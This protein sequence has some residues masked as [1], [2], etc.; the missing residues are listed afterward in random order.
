MQSLLRTKARERLEKLRS[1]A[2]PTLEDAERFAKIAQARSNF[3]VFCE[4]IRIAPKETGPRVPLYRNAIQNLFE[5]NR[6]GR[7]IALKPRQ[8]GFTTLELAR[9]LWTF[10]TRDGA[11]VVVVCQSVSDNSPA[12][13]LSGV[14]K[15]MIEGLR[16]SGWSIQFDTDAWNEWVLPN[17]NSLR[18]ISAGASDASADKKG[19]AGTITRLH[20][21]EVAF[22]EHADKTLNALLECVP[23]PETGSEI[24]LES[25]ANG[26]AGYFYQA[27][28]TS[29]AHKSVYK[30]HFYG[31]FDHPEYRVPLEPGEVV[32]PENEKEHWLVREHRVTPEQLKWRRLKIADKGEDRFDQE[33]PSDPAT[34]FLVSGRGFF[35][36]DAL[37][38]ALKGVRDPIETRDRERIRI[39]EKPEKD[40]EYLIAAD[41][42][43]GIE[44]DETDPAA[45]VLIERASGRKAAVIDGYYR[46]HQLAE[47]LA[48]L[49]TEY[50]TALVAVE[51]NN[52]GHAVLQALERELRYPRIFEDEDERPGWKT[53]QVSR[54]QMLDD[55]EAAIRTGEWSS[56]DLATIA[57]MRVFVVLNG[58]PQAAPGE[59]DDL[60]VS[61][62]IAWAIRQ[63]PLPPPPT[64]GDQSFGIW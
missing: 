44:S 9:D 37:T 50:N 3:D 21:T 47:K 32:E 10:L 31:W 23:G 7:D 49:G 62:A 14:L 60:V 34:C 40:V 56:P 55:L 22:Y 51:R 33:Y 58:K 42:S 16:S 35:E 13:L 64:L 30:F 29:I 41:A 26:A 17:G 63:R 43:E 52:H 39:Y 46:P 36:R 38:K 5:A 48:E 18:I 59:H 6:T 25:T 54:P 4:L 1:D 19:R 12:K 15:G 28:L 57:Q 11:R 20:L 45:A 8:V 2:G 53:N 61:E 24:V 27:C